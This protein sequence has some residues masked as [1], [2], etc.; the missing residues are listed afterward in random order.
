MATSIECQSLK[1]PIGIG[2]R[3]SDAL[4]FPSCPLLFIPQPHRESLF[5]IAIVKK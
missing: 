1:L 3:A 2:K 5:F 4:A